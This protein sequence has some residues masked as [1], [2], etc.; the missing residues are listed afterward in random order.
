VS[1]PSAPNEDLPT[2]LPGVVLRRLTA[3]DAP[4]YRALV[5][6]NLVHLGRDGDWRDEVAATLAEIERRFADHPDADQTFGIFEWDTLIGQV[7]LVHGAPT[8]WGLGYWLT[9]A[10]TGRGVM[11]ASIQAVLDHA[12]D[13]LG[14]TAVLASVSVGND[15]STAVLDRLAFVAVARL[16]SSTRYRRTLH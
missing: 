12:Q 9:A 4:Q 5:H 6:R 2:E 7:T 3:V 10:T 11:T 14:A 16:T 13:A 8:K 1:A 15:A